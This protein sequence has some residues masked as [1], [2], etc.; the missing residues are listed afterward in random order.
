M[1]TESSWPNVRRRPFSAGIGEA[2]VGL[3]V[4]FYNSERHSIEL[5]YSGGNGVS[6]HSTLRAMTKR[7]IVK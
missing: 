2:K 7:E 6:T 3:K 5:S 1:P 4:N